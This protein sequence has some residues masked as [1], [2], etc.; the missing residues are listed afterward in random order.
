MSSRGKKN[1]AD[2]DV[3]RMYLRGRKGK[4]L[5]E[6]LPLENALARAKVGPKNRQ[7]KPTPLGGVSCIN[8]V[9]VSAQIARKAQAARERLAVN[10]NKTC[11]KN[12]RSA[13]GSRSRSV[14]R[15]KTPLNSANQSAAVAQPEAAT[16]R[17]SSKVNQELKLKALGK[18]KRDVPSKAASVNHPDSKNATVRRKQH[19][20]LKYEGQPRF[21][22]GFR[23]VQGGLPELGRR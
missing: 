12:R 1:A 22:N 15:L 2:S 16:V 3:R 10:R 14:M 6:V 18:R 23:I 8:P 5:V 20:V 19:A 4:I 17:T 9:I 11:Q 13:G 7:T 21:V